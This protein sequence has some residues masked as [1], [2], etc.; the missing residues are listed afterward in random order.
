MPRDRLGDILIKAGLLDQAGLQRALNEQ[1]R[2]GGLLGQYLVQLNLISEENLV[3]AL[4]AQYKLPAV[5]LDPPKL[6]IAVAQLVPQR[7][8]EKHCLVCFRADTKKRF[9]DVAMANPAMTDAIDEVRVATQYNVRPYIAGP[10]A[11]NAAIRFVFYGDLHLGDE[12]Q[13]TPSSPL[14]S[15]HRPPPPPKGTGE[16]ATVKRLAIDPR[17]Q[18]GG[19]GS[20]LPLGEPISLGVEVT[21]RRTAPIE[22]KDSGFHISLDAPALEVEAPSAEVTVEERLNYLEALAERDSLILERLLN[23]LLNKKL[24]SAEEIQALMRS[25]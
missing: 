10:G 6:D 22:P 4:S 7:I 2:W 24:L 3:R 25:K 13:L 15:D 20:D 21:K 23:A 9:L 11:I 12:V 1:R 14:R 8:C 5:A 19:P 17:S 18:P 16:S